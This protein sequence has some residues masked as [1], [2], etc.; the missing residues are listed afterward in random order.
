MCRQ[1]T[2]RWKVLQY[3]SMKVYISVRINCH[4]STG[5]GTLTTLTQLRFSPITVAFT[6][7][8]KILKVDARA[9]GIYA[10]FC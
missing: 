8:G 10:C 3:V 1:S 7:S 6:V 4:H 2:V 9:S 5:N